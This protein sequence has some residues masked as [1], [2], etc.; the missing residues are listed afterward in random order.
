M[1]NA[2]L[3]VEQEATPLNLSSA[4][5]KVILT[6]VTNGSGS[7]Y[8]SQQ[9]SAGGL[10]A[11]SKVGTG[12]GPIAKTQL[13]TTNLVQAGSACYI[14]EI[15]YKYNPP[16]PLRIVSPSGVFYDVAYFQ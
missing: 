2:L 10:S 11:S 6:A 7:L 15:F 3:A 16:A 8:I 12:L 4:S 14:A 13:P 1:T 9:V 5:A